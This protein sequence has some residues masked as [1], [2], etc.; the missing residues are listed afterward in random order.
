MQLDGTLGNMWPVI[1]LQVNELK[2]VRNMCGTK[3]TSPWPR[4]GWLVHSNLG[5]HEEK[6]S[7]PQHDQ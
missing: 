3:M 4:I 5:Q 2:K 6:N 1:S 7:K